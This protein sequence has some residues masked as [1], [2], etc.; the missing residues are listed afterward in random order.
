MKKKNDVHLEK[1]CKES[2][3]L[4]GEYAVASELC[5]RGHY[6]QLTL[7]SHKKTDLLVEIQS[8]ASGDTFRRISVKA[9]LG[10]AWPKVTGIGDKGDILIFVDFRGKEDNE[11]PDFYVLDIESWRSVVKI[12]KSQHKD[13]KIDK[14]MNTL[15]WEPWEGNDKGWRGCE[16]HPEDIVN[17]K[18]QWKNVDK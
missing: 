3:G 18:E 7:G 11:R 4:A 2:V 12:K 6:A 10:N 14:K 16:V 13:S 9:K 8:N 5:R 1:R 17:F 15:Y